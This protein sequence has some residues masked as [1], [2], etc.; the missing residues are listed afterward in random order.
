MYTLMFVLK[1]VRNPRNANGLWQVDVFVPKMVRNP[2]NVNGLW[3]VDL[4]VPKVSRN[5][6]WL[7]VVAS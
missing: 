6:R 5:T 4:F 3:Q 1:M 7:D 2:H